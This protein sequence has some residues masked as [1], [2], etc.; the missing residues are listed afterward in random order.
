MTFIANHYGEIHKSIYHKSILPQIF[1]DY[2]HKNQT[3]YSHHT[4]QKNNLHL[5]SVHSIFGQK[6]LS[7]YIFLSFLFLGGQ[8]C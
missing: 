1:L 6:V 3:I 5:Y 2:F 7:V 4:R 8:L